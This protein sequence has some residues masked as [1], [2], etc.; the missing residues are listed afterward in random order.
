MKKLS[1]KLSLLCAVASFASVPSF[2]G[3]DDGVEDLKTLAARAVSKKWAQS[4]IS[5]KDIY[6][7]L[8]ETPSE[9]FVPLFETL[10]LQICKKLY[11]EDKDKQILTPYLHKGIVLHL[12]KLGI[13]GC[14]KLYAEDKD[15]KFLTPFLREALEEEEVSLEKTRQ[16]NIWCISHYAK[17]RKYIFLQGTFQEVV[18][19]PFVS[20]SL[21]GSDFGKLTESEAQAFAQSPIKRLEL[22]S[23]CL[24][25]LEWFFPEANPSSDKPFFQYLRQLKLYKLSPMQGDEIVKFILQ[26][27]IV[28]GLTHFDL[29]ESYCSP[30]LVQTIT[31]NPL[32]LNLTH[33]DL[34]NSLDKEGLKVLVECESFKKLTHLN[35]SKNKLN[36]KEFK[37]LLQ[38]KN[39]KSLQSL[40]VD[41]NEID[42]E[43]FE[44]CL[45]NLT[46][47]SLSENRIS[48]EGIKFLVQNPFNNLI[49]L[50]LRKNS[51]SV[52]GFKTIAQGQNFKQLNILDLRHNV[53]YTTVESQRAV[54]EIKI[55][56]PHLKKCILSSFE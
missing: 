27:P 43:E 30:E 5:L 46:H 44:L 17:G 23:P 38:S 54:E 7:D 13:E 50:N 15:Q 34:G 16:K 1:L 31:Q 14:M 49:Y 20:F 33:L 42:I 6:A 53:D 41:C 24:Q 8:F 9:L 21:R 10:D 11:E 40:E 37:A 19:G 45:D 35:L 3:N 47:L 29:S 39:F 25:N 4:N 18:E 36:G 51:I 52:D 22:F 12:K 26:S 55:G 2:A 56:L 28:Y 48:D 32:C